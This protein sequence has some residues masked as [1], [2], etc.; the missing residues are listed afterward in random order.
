M[1]NIIPILYVQID[2]SDYC[3]LHSHSN[4]TDLGYM[5]D[6]Y[7]DLCYNLGVNIL[8]YDYAG[9]GQSTG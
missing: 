8:A 5:L 2:K 3:I 7:K 4:A 6:N 1:N 9:Y